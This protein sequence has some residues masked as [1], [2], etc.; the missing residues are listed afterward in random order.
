MFDTVVTGG[1]YA[2]W[3]LVALIWTAGA[4]LGRKHPGPTRKAGRDIAS[5]AAAV[6]AV[7]ILLTPAHVWQ[8]LT[9]GSPWIR[10]AGLVMLIGATAWT[11][12]ARLTLGSMWS[13]GAVAQ[14]GHV[15]R[16]TGPYGV[17]RHP[18][19]TG[20]L[21]MLA[22]SALAEGLGRWLALFIVVALLL[23]AKTR[24]EERLLA[25]EFPA[26]YEAYRRDVPR[27]IPRIR[28]ARAEQG[29]AAHDRS[30]SPLDDGGRRP[31]S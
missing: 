23:L 7:V 1:T 9:V 13:S 28:P 5:P 20:I 10:G 29:G 17:T 21:G 31:G 26:E 14:Q 27:L 6:A 2:C 19:Y 12:W 16:T 11:V 15:L 4:V 25:E 24:A 3:G 8:A 18:V 22:G 30:R